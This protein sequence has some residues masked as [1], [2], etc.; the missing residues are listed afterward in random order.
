MRQVPEP[1]REWVRRLR[2]RAR[3]DAEEL[4]GFSRGVHNLD[5]DT[6]L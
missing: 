6:A 3:L 5:G 1:D 4:L 2:E